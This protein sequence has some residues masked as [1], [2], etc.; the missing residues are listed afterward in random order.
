VRNNQ[1]CESS[2]DEPRIYAIIV[3]QLADTFYR[4]IAKELGIGLA[5]AELAAPI[6]VVHIAIEVHSARRWHI[7]LI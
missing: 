5:R 1:L 3:A 4:A 7:Q 2:T 6:C